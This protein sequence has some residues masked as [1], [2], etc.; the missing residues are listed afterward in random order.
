MCHDVCIIKQ[1]GPTVLPLP[2]CLYLASYLPSGFFHDMW[3][4]HSLRESAA[5]SLQAAATV[6]QLPLQSLLI[7]GKARKHSTVREA[8]KTIRH[9]LCD[10]MA[11]Y[12]LLITT[13]LDMLHSHR[14][15][16]EL[17]LCRSF[18]TKHLWYSDPGQRKSAACSL[19]QRQLVSRSSVVQTSV[20]L[21]MSVIINNVVQ[22]FSATKTALLQGICRM[23]PNFSTHLTS[24]EY[25]IASSTDEILSH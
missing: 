9:S 2:L 6:L 1:P 14:S 21:L 16:W 17:I 11:F 13:P 3:Y 20:I 22:L 24:V 7:P 12:S 23:S 18:V 5:V 19:G 15:R 25:C 4:L 8:S 10:G